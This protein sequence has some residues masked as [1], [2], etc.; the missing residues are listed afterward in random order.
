MSAWPLGLE[1]HRSTIETFLSEHQR[2]LE[3]ALLGVY[4]Y[5]SRVHNLSVGAA[6]DFDFVVVVKASLVDTQKAELLAL[7]GLLPLPLDT[8]Y[9]PQAHLNQEVV[10]ALVECV[11]RSVVRGIR[12]PKLFRVSE[13]SL[14][15]PFVRQE[16]WDHGHCLMGPAI[17]T[18]FASVSEGVLRQ[19]LMLGVPHILRFPFPVLQMCRG[20]YTASTLRICT[21]MAAGEWAFQTLPGHWHW[22]IR[23]EMTAYQAGHAATSSDEVVVHSFHQYY[24]ER[25]SVTCSR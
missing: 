21:K 22:L 11:I 9:V 10:P 18:L 15:F 23:D 7:H 25:I 12:A 14:D 16:V 13:G 2:L 17:P 6:S 4:A 19:A 5:G 24:T 1:P 20:L 8:T 3:A